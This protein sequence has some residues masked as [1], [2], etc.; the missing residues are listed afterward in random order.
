MGGPFGSV[1]GV[2]DGRLGE[3]RLDRC[4]KR[5]VLYPTA[6]RKYGG[7]DAM[8]LRKIHKVLGVS[9]SPF[10]LLLASTGLALLWRKNNLYSQETKRLLVGLHT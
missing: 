10:L 2:A 3:T 8:N 7:P 6:K 1:L 9:M 5:H 4:A